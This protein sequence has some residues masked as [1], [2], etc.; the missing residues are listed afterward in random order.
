MTVKLNQVLKRV[1]ADGRLGKK[2]VEDLVKAANDGKGI[3]KAEAERLREI[4]Q[5][6]DKMLTKGARDGFDAFLQ[7]MNRSWSTKD[8]VHMPHLDDKKIRDLINSDPRIGIFT[9]RS[10]GGKGG[11]STRPTRPTPPPR[12]APTRPGK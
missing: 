5:E 7:A 9:P 1:S 3:T 2:D 10:G 11:G 6:F 12:P 8:N 4:R